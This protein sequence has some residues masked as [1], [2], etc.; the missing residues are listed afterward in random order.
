M[1][2]KDYVALAAALARTRPNPVVTSCSCPHDVPGHVNTFTDGI[3]R[4]QWVTVRD[5]IAEA[6]VADNPTFDLARFA[7]ATE[8]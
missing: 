8:A 2:R 7:R 1:T 3:S 6:L 5:G 4:K